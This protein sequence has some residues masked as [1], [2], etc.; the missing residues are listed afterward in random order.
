MR[1][2]KHGGS[3]VWGRDGEGGGGVDLVFDFESRESFSLQW[4]KD[5][6]GGETNSGKSGTSNLEAQRVLEIERRV[7]E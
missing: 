2:G 7:R 4:D 1:N 5:K 6:K 3:I